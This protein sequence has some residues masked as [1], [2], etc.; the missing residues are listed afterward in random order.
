MVHEM[1]GYKTASPPTCPGEAIRLIW[2]LV[3]ILL[4]GSGIAYLEMYD[5]DQGGRQ[6][7][8]HL[9]LMLVVSLAI[10]IIAAIKAPLRGLYFDRDTFTRPARLNLSLAIF[11]TICFALLLHAPSSQDCHFGVTCRT[12]PLLEL[13]L[14]G[15]H[16]GYSM[17]AYILRLRAS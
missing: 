11:W 2:V 6:A 16:Y 1:S 3:L 13:A 5:L 10:S 9:S 7:L 4:P 17:T 12:Y 14:A 15:M 8:V